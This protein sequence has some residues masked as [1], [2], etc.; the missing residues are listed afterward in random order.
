MPKW[1]HVAWDAADV[2]LCGW[3]ACDWERPGCGWM[4][5]GGGWWHVH[6]SVLDWAGWD[7][8]G[9]DVRG[10]GRLGREP[11]AVCLRHVGS[12]NWGAV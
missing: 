5:G 4:W 3:R 6:R 12:A 2:C 7:E 9:Y 10:W 8:L 1:G 11:A